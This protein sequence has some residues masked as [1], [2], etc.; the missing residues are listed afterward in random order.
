MLDLILILSLSH[1]FNDI[2]LHLFYFLNSYIYLN[3][4]NNL[5]NLSF[6]VLDFNLIIKKKTFFFVQ[7]FITH[8]SIHY[9]KFIR[10]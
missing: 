5:L 6:L 10:L 7:V 9:D 8:L 1:S 3:K 2:C 4:E